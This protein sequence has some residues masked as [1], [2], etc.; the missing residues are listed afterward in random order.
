MLR[1]FYVTTVMSIIVYITA[2][3]VAKIF[4]NEPEIISI[5]VTYIRIIVIIYP[6]VSIAL[7][8][9]RIL[10]GLGLGLPLLIVTTIRVL[11]VSAPL[12]L[13]FN[14]IYHKPIE[15]MWYSMMMATVVAVSTATFWLRI[16]LRKRAII[17]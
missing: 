14:Y 17:A 2:P 7:T 10:Q 4:T 16:A 11:G 9:G 5:A 15:W 8:S 13:I 3:I 12:A 6:L 1:S